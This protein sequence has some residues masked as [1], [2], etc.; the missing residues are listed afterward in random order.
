MNN[1]K[2]GILLIDKEVGI[3][4]YDEIRKVKR[5]FASRGELKGQKIGHAGTLDPF[6]SGLLIIMLGKDCR[7]FDEFQKMKK[8]YVVRAEFGYET[9]TQDCTG[10]VIF[11]DESELWKGLTREDVEAEISKSFVGEIL[12]IPPI[13]SAKKVDGKRAYDLAREGKEI[14]LQPKIVNVYEFRVIEWYLPF[15]RF[16]IVC[17]SGTYIRTLVRDLAAKLGTRATAVE[18]RR[19][20]VGEYSL[21]D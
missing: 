5:D 11:R 8:T 21:N 3:S 18:L 12:Q 10:E 15:V 14:V 13:Y 1:V 16:E 17:S 20:R 9:D 4:S 7:R 2:D 19:T 6:A